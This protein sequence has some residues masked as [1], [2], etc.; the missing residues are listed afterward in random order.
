MTVFAESCYRPGTRV[1]CMWM[2][3][4]VV[5]LVFNLWRYSVCSLRDTAMDTWVWVTS[6]FVPLLHS[7]WTVAAVRWPPMYMRGSCALMFAAVAID[8]I[9]LL[10]HS[11]PTCAE[12]DRPL[13]IFLAML[14]GSHLTLTLLFAMSGRSV[15][16]A[17]RV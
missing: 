2:M 3:A 8:L 13:L 12:D 14:A 17:G 1:V 5:A 11:K 15:E 9:M 7:I 4:A 10:P 6:V 16:N